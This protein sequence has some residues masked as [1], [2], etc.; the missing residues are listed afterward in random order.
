LYN[1][2]HADRLIVG[3]RALQVAVHDVGWQR[4]DSAMCGAVDQRVGGIEA[5]G[6]LIQKGEEVLGGVVLS[7]PPNLIVQVEEPREAERGD[8]RQLLRQP[9]RQPPRRLHPTR[10]PRGVAA[11]EPVSSFELTLPE[12]KYSALAAKNSPDPSAEGVGDDRTTEG[13]PHRARHHHSAGRD[14]TPRTESTLQLAPPAAIAS[15]RPAGDQ[16]GSRRP[17]RR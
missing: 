4:L 8:Q 5:E 17:A 1:E 13:C 11:L 2:V 14:L 10:I 15:P 3:Q 12:G 6:S 9:P 16:A 7:D